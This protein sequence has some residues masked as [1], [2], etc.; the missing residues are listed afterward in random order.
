MSEK[1]VNNRNIADKNMKSLRTLGLL[2]AA[3]LVGG[4]YLGMIG[5]PVDGADTNRTGNDSRGGLPPVADAGPDQEVTVGDTV[6][7]DGSNSYDPDS[8]F[9]RFM[10]S[11]GD[12]ASTEWDHDSTTSHTYDSIGN[13]TVTL[14]IVDDL[15]N[16]TNAS[17][18]TDTCLVNVKEMK[19]EAL[20]VGPREEY[21]KIQDAIDAA[22]RGDTVYVS[23]GTYYEN[24]IVNKSVNLVGAGREHTTIDAGGHADG[25][26][27]TAD[28]VRLSGFKIIRT[29]DEDDPDYDSAIEINDADW[30]T[31]ENNNCSDNQYGIYLSYAYN[32]NIS[33]NLCNNNKGSGIYIQRSLYNN[34][35]DNYCNSNGNKD[36]WA[37]R[38]MIVANSEGCT[39]INNNCAENLRSGI[40]LTN[41]DNCLISNNIC[42]LNKENGIELGST[43]SDGGVIANNTC[44]ENDVGIHLDGRGLVVTNNSCHLNSIGISTRRSGQTI[45]KNTISINKNYGMMILSDISSDNGIYH[46]NFID[47]NNGNIQALDDGLEYGNGSCNKWNTLGEGNFWSDLT[48]PDINGDDIVDIPYEIDGDANLKDEYPLVAPVHYPTP[49]ADGGSNIVKF[50]HQA[51][52]FNGTSSWGYPSIT[53]YSWSFIYNSTPTNL[54]GQIPAFTFHTVGIYEIKLTVT[55]EAGTRGCDLII[56]E[57]LDVD[58]PI[59]DAGPDKTIGLGELIT[60]NAINSRD[61]MGIVN[62]SWSFTYNN[63]EV[64]LYGISPVFNFEIIGLYYLT[65]NVTDARGNWAIDTM[66]I[67]VR[68]SIKPLAKAGEDDTIN[69]H[70]T[71][72]F[73]AGEGYDNIEITNYTWF[74]V[75]DNLEIYLY[76][77]TPVFDFQAVGIYIV[78][79]NVSDA[80]GN[81][82]IDSLTITV[83]DIV[84]PVAYAGP[85]ATIKE[86]ETAFFDGGGSSDNVAIANFTWSFFYIDGDINLWGQKSDYIF[87]VPD[88]YTITLKVTDVA[89]NVAYDDMILIVLEKKNDIITDENVSEDDSDGDGYNDTYENESGSDPNDPKSTPYDWDGDGV[90]NKEDAYPHDPSRWSK[91]ESKTKEIVLWIG[92]F[93]VILLIIVLCYTRIR[94]RNVLKNAN[95]NDIYNFINE[96]PGIHRSK[97]KRKLRI[98]DGTLSHHLRKL[99]QARRIQT[100][101]D[102]KYNYYYTN[103]VKNPLSL[104]P[105]QRKIVDILSKRES[106][107][108]QELADKLG[109]ER[110]TIVYHMNNLSDKGVLNSERTNKKVYWSVTDET[111]RD[112]K[113]DN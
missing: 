95:R 77:K 110:H 23:T 111:L 103:D 76:G 44:V 91:D 87:E 45:S 51:V 53:N 59:P 41:S 96:N 40:Y 2:V 10:W 92:L 112:Y 31:I 79:L 56:V 5:G 27:I 101:R 42:N 55:S 109:K 71:F 3:M 15:L 29:G 30:C 88:N 28:N 98:S 65:L 37:A 49:I 6:Y 43:P 86:G 72:H 48:G 54:Y 38:G 14:T 50:Q 70:S 68:D 81:W 66:L 83:K 99:Q 58:P 61:N 63:S 90:S 75:Y 21:T 34:I 24:V 17:Y 85:D 1:G 20:Y 74:F 16:N 35:I 105:F 67:D 93:S 107:T 26:L 18:D 104:T 57:V 22:D 84:P 36:Y 97:I 80:E 4:V 32:N 12:G 100:R 39:I 33:N 9:L 69:L 113:D 25:I 78:M 19:M 89:G 7:F 62:Y 46:N 8:G 13:Y 108:T 64:T 73:D 11:F 106:C 47:N 82:D 94:N 102:G 60:F 52:V